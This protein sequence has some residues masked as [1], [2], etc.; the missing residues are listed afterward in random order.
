[1]AVTTPLTIVHTSDWHLGHELHA[2]PREAEHDAFLAWLLDRLETLGA[3]C[4]LV[5]GDIYDV[6]NP[7]TA[8]IQRLFRFLRDA[9]ARMPRLQIVIT[10]GNHDSA[11]RVDLPGALVDNTRLH[12][13]GKLPRRE[14]EDW[15]RRR[16]GSGN[17][18]GSESG[19]GNRNGSGNESE[20]EGGSEV[21]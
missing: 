19:T 4:L 20:D 21:G 3:D 15:E 12:L 5:A 7:P 10:G 11:A 17:A 8:A 16:N 18:N 9:M 2:H 1:M 13:V 6:A 14:G